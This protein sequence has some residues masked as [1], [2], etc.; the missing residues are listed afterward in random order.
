MSKTLD[1]VEYK[2]IGTKYRQ[3]NRIKCTVCGAVT[4]ADGQKKTEDYLLRTC[5]FCDTIKT[6]ER[7][8]I[9]NQIFDREKKSEI[10]KRYS[11]GSDN[12][13]K[14][15]GLSKTPIYRVWLNM[16]SRCFDD[17]REHWDVY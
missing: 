13:A 10:K 5:N 4:Y 2:K 3:C 9:V 7:R 1:G 11:D 15:H 17:N 12:R 14:R 6:A 8:G 16:M